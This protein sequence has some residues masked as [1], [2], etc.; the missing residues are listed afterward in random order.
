MSMRASILVP[1]KTA[2]S[3]REAEMPSGRPLRPVFKG[4]VDL[5]SRGTHEGEWEL[6]RLSVWVG[7]SLTSRRGR[8]GEANDPHGWWFLLG[9]PKSFFFALRFSG[10]TL[11][12][13][14]SMCPLGIALASPPRALAPPT[15]AEGVQGGGSPRGVAWG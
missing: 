7:P 14:T 8:D 5:P 2:Q 13:S 9:A 3:C 4:R 11:V 15:P 1:P 6:R 12:S 10:P